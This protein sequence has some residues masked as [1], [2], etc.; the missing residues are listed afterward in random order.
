MHGKKFRLCTSRCREPVSQNFADPPKI[1]GVFIGTFDRQTGTNQIVHDPAYDHFMDQPGRRLCVSWLVCAPAIYLSHL[2]C[3]DFR[4]Q[5]S[6]VFRPVIGILK[7]MRGIRR[8]ESTVDSNSLSNQRSDRLGLLAVSLTQ[9][10]HFKR[11]LSEALPYLVFYRGHLR[12]L[13]LVNMQLQCEPI[14]PGRRRC[15]KLCLQ[16]RKYPRILVAE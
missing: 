12:Q 7:Y 11:S 16:V 9:P 1:H 4:S 8:G 6:G 3:P 13:A 5:F 10:F 15:R 2:L 14:A